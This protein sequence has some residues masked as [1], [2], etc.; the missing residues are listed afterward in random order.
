MAVSNRPAV[1]SAV[2]GFALLIVIVVFI[3]NSLY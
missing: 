1:T 2:I 3:L